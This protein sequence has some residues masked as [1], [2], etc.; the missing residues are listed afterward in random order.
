MTYSCVGLGPS[1]QVIVDLVDFT[2][3][4]KARSLIYFKSIPEAPSSAPKPC[5]DIQEAA[6]GNDFDSFDSLYN[7]VTEKMI[8]R[9]ID[10]E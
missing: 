1:A 9:V 5:F 2:A 3:G 7:A 4:T 8:T 6:S 10:N